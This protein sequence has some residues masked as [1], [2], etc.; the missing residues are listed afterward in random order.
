MFTGK[1][2]ASLTGEVSLP[3]LIEIILRG[4]WPGSRSLSLDSA[5]LVS[6]QYIKAV[7]EDDVYRVDDTKRNNH[8]IELLLSSLA[9]NESTT[10]TNKTLKNYIKDIYNEDI[11]IDT[12]AEYLDVLSQLFI[13]ENQNPLL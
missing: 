5:M 12:I 8:K 3:F 1:F 10:V 9:R 2:T 11:N 6:K 4:G 13:I 7:L